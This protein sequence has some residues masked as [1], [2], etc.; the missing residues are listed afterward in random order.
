MGASP[1]AWR[2]LGS[3]SSAATPVLKCVHGY[4]SG[5][6]TRWLAESL[7]DL[8][9]AWS[10]PVVPNAWGY[11]MTDLPWGFQDRFDE[12]ADVEVLDEDHWELDG[13]GGSPG[14]ADDGTYYLIRVN[15]EYLVFHQ[16][17][18]E[19]TEEG[20]VAAN[21]DTSAIRV[22]RETYRSLPDPAD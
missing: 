20:S 13:G 12:D 2:N 4:G 10:Y 9:H 21:T 11:Y 16:S 6:A 15:G 19:T 1:L 5:L 22:F 8:H 17:G 14:N 3:D 7:R 18:G